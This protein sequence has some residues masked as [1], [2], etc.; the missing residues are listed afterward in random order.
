MVRVPSHICVDG[1]IVPLV[2]D[3]EDHRGPA[4]V[5][6]LSDPQ[7]PLLDALV[8]VSSAMLARPPSSTWLECIDRRADLPIPGYVSATVVRPDVDDYSESADVWRRLTGTEVDLHDAYFLG[9]SFVDHFIAIPRT[10]FRKVMARLFELDAALQAG[11]LEPRIDESMPVPPPV[12][13]PPERTER[14]AERDWWA[15]E[16]SAQDLDEHDPL[17]DGLTD[18]A[19]AAQAWVDRRQVLDALT[20]LHERT[21]RGEDDLPGQCRAF[22]LRT[23]TAYVAATEALEAYL[24]DPERRALITTAPPASPYLADV[25]VDLFRL[26]A[27]ATPPGLSW[28]G[29]LARC[30]AVFVRERKP[31]ETEAG[32]LFTRV[33]G[34]LVRLR[35]APRRRR[36]VSGRGLRG[37]AMARTAGQARLSGVRPDSSG[38]RPKPANPDSGAA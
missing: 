22:E 37:R 2:I 13:E 1:L 6:V 31:P 32:D 28:H 16:F 38:F 26:P 33:A 20:I 24:A 11:E 17:T 12:P 14:W 23:L 10:T 36:R 27:P 35:Y 9:T 4:A 25:S 19:Q 30:E 18:A 3:P 34:H 8:Y 7:R 29:W 15:L 5:R 21:L